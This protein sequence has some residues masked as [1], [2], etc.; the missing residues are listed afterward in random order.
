LITHKQI[1]KQLLLQEDEKGRTP[2][3]EALRR[4]TAECEELI[5]QLIHATADL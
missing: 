4:H 3:D 5:R 2:L 1:I